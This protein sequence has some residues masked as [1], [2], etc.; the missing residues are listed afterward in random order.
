MNRS[1]AGTILLGLALCSV[2]PAE[3]TPV[4]NP[5]FEMVGSNLIH[6]CST[7][8]GPC[9]FSS[10]GVIPDW[11]SQ[12]GTAGQILHV[13]NF[14]GTGGNPPATEGNYI[15]FSDDPSIWQNT[16]TVVG[17]ETYTL[18]VDV[19]HRI[20][21]NF[22][23]SIELLLGSGGLG[24]TIVGTLTG[25]DPGAGHWTTMTDV[26]TADALQ[27]G[28][29]LTVVLNASGLQGDFDN[30]RLSGDSGAATPEP[31]TLALFGSA[32]VGLGLLRRKRI[33]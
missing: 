16:G 6:P 22:D 15:A 11:T 5:S 26:F 3:I 7:S 23:G 24:G 18:S 29:T 1:L 33:V 12:P 17:G 32:L 14:P 25:S 4:L 8:L 13:E 27:D 10:D 21:S 2:A 9:F 20:D 30:V 28:K 31:G 19:L